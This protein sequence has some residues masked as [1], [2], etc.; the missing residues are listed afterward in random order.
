MARLG[1]SQPFPFRRQ[2]KLGAANIVL[3]GTIIGASETNIVSGGRTIILTLTGDSWVAA[4]GT[5]DA[6][7]QNIINGLTSAQAEAAGWNAVVKATAA[8]TDVV[9]TSASV[10]TI[11]LE[12]FASYNITTQETI[13]ATVPGSALLLGGS[14]VAAPTFTITAVGGTG[15]IS[16]QWITISAFGPTMFRAGRAA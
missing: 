10:V 4:G 9:R 14:I 8:V 12:A 3:S 15:D 7:R 5:F 11:T 13:T 6:Q 1:R 16:A 2:Q